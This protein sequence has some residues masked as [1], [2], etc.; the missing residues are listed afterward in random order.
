MKIRQ[1]DTSNRFLV[2]TAFHRMEIIRDDGLYRHLRMKQPGTSCYYFDII[3]WP[4]YLT[5]TGDMGTWTFSRIADMFNFFGP[6]DSEINTGYWSEKLEAG[7][8]CS[9]R[10]LLAKDFDED[11]FCESLKEYFSEYLEVSET[12]DSDVD[13]DCNDDGISDRDKRDIREIVSDLCSA[14]FSNEHDAYQA[15]YDADWPEG[16][17][18]WDICDGLTFKTYTSHFRWILFAITWAISKYHNTK[19]VDKAMV[20]YLAVKGVAA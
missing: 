17:S 20:T 13:D 8:G 3:T 9:A 12:H 15:V 18:A 7:A 10:E 19:L 5:V 1:F 14:N 6:W 2:D 4:G 16:F 11:E